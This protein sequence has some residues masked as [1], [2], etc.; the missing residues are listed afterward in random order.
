MYSLKRIIILYPFLLLA[1]SQMND[2]VSIILFH[3]IVINI[4]HC[5]NRIIESE[6]FLTFQ[7]NYII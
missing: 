6:I 5:E 7:I 3:K 1:M 2:Y 4:V